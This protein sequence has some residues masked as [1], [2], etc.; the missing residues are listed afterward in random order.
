MTTLEPTT[1]SSFQVSE[2]SPPAEKQSQEDHQSYR[3]I[4][5]LAHEGICKLNQVGRTEFVNLR[6]AEMLN[7]PAASLDNKSL[8]DIV[9][10]ISIPLLEVAWRE[11]KSL[12]AQQFDCAFRRS[13]DRVLWTICSST[14]L[15]NSTGRFAGAVLFFTDITERRQI[16]EDLRCAIRKADEAN[17][18]KSQ[19]LANMSHEIRTP[20]GAVLGFA[21]LLQDEKQSEGERNECIS[22]IRRNGEALLNLVNDILDLAKVEAGAIQLDIQPFTLMEVIEELRCTFSRQA[23]GKGLQFEIVAEGDLTDLGKIPAPLHIVSDAMKLRQILFNVIGNALKFTEKG[24]VVAH[25]FRRRDALVCQVQDTGPGIEPEEAGRLFAP[26]SQA[27]SSINR[28]LGGTGLGLVLARNLA[29]ALGGNVELVSSEVGHG[30]LFEISLKICLQSEGVMRRATQK[31]LNLR[32]SSNSSGPTLFQPLENIRFE[33]V[34]ILL[35]DDCHDSRTL[36]QRMLAPTGAHLTLACN[37]REGVER[38]VAGRFDVILMDIQMP[39]MDGYEAT[40]T[41]RARG[42]RGT[43]VALT[44]HAMKEERERCLAAGC[45]EHLIKPLNRRT[46]LE[47]LQRSLRTQLLF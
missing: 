11:L 40:T 35:V 18:A 46:L 24:K 34:E 20:L 41:L 6:L 5:Q 33:H 47:C 23:E 17:A 2:D 26:F 4:V 37:G 14:P 12:H 16:Q 15:I 3:S 44:A 25:F 19:F 39:V 21:E 30:S 22:A 7:R 36:A 43:I 10:T 1:C 27:D 45:N 31:F 42:Y 8:W 38:A 32:G 29:R 13:D 9:D 28:K